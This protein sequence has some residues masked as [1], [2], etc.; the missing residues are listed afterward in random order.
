MQIGALTY[1]STLSSAEVPVRVTNSSSK[2][3]DYFITI[4]LEDAKGKTQLDTT[5][6]FVTNLEPGQTSRRKGVF[7]SLSNAPPPGSKLVL[8]SVDRLASS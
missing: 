5:D 3:S 6:V 4:A 8:Q 1:D 2:R 7:L